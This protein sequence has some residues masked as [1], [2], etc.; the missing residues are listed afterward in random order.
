MSKSTSAI[1]AKGKKM[2]EV[3]HNSGVNVA[4]VGSAF[5]NSTRKV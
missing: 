3:K 2:E 1:V 5:H 4:S